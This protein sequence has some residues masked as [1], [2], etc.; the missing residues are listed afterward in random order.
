MS[1]QRSD[2]TKSNTAAEK[3]TDT[4]ALLSAEELRAISGGYSPPM[5][6]PPI[7]VPPPNAGG[8]TASGKT[9]G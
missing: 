8:P 7:P 3:K 5:P 4:T 1:S 6:P 2:Q 9:V